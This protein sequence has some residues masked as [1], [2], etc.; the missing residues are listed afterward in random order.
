MTPC[1]GPTPQVTGNIFDVSLFESD[2]DD[3]GSNN[4]LSVWI[5]ISDRF[6]QEIHTDKVMMIMEQI[7][8]EV[9]FVLKLG[10]RPAGSS[11]FEVSCN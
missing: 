3:G 2:T 11:V 9:L 8:L 6:L 10:R 4:N 5:S 7:T 1:L